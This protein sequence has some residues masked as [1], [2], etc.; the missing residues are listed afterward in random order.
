MTE[1]ILGAVLTLSK[2]DARQQYVLFFWLIGVFLFVVIL[3]TVLVI[4]FPKHLLARLA[5]DL[6]RGRTAAEILASPGF[7]DIVEK[8]VR[9][10]VQPQA[11]RGED[12][13]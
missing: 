10:T 8:V 6:E 3:V 13:K 4:A 11:L 2:M 12:P 1:A 5:Q 7:N 9:E